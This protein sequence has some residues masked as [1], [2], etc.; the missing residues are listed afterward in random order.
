MDVT[1]RSHRL[2]GMRIKYYV[3]LRCTL[4]GNIHRTYNRRE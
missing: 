4:R 2:L 1:Y 3:V